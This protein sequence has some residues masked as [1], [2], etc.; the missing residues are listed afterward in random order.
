MTKIYD[1]L[2]DADRVILASPIFF[3]ALSAQTKIMIDRC[4]AFWCEKYLLKRPIHATKYGRK[5]LLLIVAGMKH[6]KELQCAEITAKG[7]FRTVSIQEH[8]TLSVPGVDEKET[9]LRHPTAM[10][11]AYEAG[12]ALIK[13]SGER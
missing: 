12:K 1:A 5:A 8:S 7:F 6:E 2:R 13:V 10:N 9:I 11:D 3:F 4:Q